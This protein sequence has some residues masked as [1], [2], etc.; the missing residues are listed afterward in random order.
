MQFQIIQP[1]PLLA[2]YIK[3]YWVL[4]AQRGEDPVTERVVP[5]AQV[6]LMF[7]YNK[8]FVNLDT[9]NTYQQQARSV[10]SGPGNTWVDVSTQGEAGAIAVS[11]LPGGASNFFNFPISEIQGN[12]YALDEI[13][14]RE[15]AIVE[16]QINMAPSTP[17]R[18]AVIENF[19]LDRLKPVNAYKY[20]LI[21]TGIQHI[22]TV[23]G[24]LTANALAEKLCTSPK[25]LERYFSSYIGKTP[26]QIIQLIRFQQVMNELT[27]TKPLSLT[28][29]A[30][31]NGFFDQA[32][33]IRDFKKYSGYT[34][35][36]MVRNACLNISRPTS[37]L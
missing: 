31:A 24:Q 23:K 21:C 9:G 29:Y 34:P 36:E 11:F 17:K 5:T 30:Y 3:H 32:H 33:F 4:E 37:A 26:K 12:S 27:S 35:G 25:T 8:P 15:S 19:L 28:E 6:E 7:H 2:P 13:V 10:I 18:I 22:E 16:E 14:A 1:S 20:R